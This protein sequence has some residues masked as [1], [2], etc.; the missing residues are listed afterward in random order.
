MSRSV[1]GWIF[2][3]IMFAT[4]GLA[5]PNARAQKMKPGLHGMAPSKW[6]RLENTYA[7][8]RIYAANGALAREY[9][10]Q[11][12]Y[13]KVYLP[14]VHKKNFNLLLGPSYR[15]EQIA[16]DDDENSSEDPLKRMSN[17]NLRS[18]GVD[19]RAIS[20]IDSTSW[21][22][23]NLNINQSGNLREDDHQVPLNYTLS[24]VFL[25][26][27]SAN[28]EIGFGLMANR[29]FGR[30]VG[31]PVVVF[32]YNFSSKLGLELMLP[33]R[34]ALRYNL[35]PSEILLLKADALSRS[36]YIN[37]TD[38]EYAFRRTELDLGLEYN[39]Q[40]GKLLGIELFGGYRQNIST[41]LP[42]EISAVK[43]SGLVFS[44]GLYL[45]SPVQK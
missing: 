44:F 39:K 29:S 20:T 38:A 36:Y 8:G 4:L 11:D 16:L 30:V 35:S 10:Q 5:C 41:R 40:L 15:L 24:A 13:F 26:K 31:F 28:K 3:G 9:T 18:L 23:L 14:V 2:I 7:P 33:R 42:N 27:K 45:K 19:I 22:M 6:I 1:P 32:N 17:W 21:L 12:F 25:R 37:D 43:T 34:A